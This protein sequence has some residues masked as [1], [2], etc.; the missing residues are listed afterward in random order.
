MFKKVKLNY[1]NA[2]PVPKTKA[3]LKVKRSELIKLDKGIKEKCK[4][5]NPKLSREEVDC[6]TLLKRLKRN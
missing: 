6:P 4:N 5:N 1:R 3:G 2:S